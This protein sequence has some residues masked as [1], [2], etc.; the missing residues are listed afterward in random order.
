MNN[1]ATV[2]VRHRMDSFLLRGKRSRMWTIVVQHSRSFRYLEAEE[3]WSYEASTARAFSRISDAVEHC[4]TN[5]L[6]D[7]HIVMGHLRPD[8]RFNSASKTIMRLPRM[9]SLEHVQ[10]RTNQSALAG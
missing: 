5:G 2:S 9:I 4:A 6:K 8:G 10:S 3:D 7:V 1:F